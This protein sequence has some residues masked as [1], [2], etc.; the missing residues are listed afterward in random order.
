MK[1]QL[2]IACLTLITLSAT[3]QE[4]KESK[5]KNHEITADLD[6][7]AGQSSF[8]LSLDAHYDWFLLKSKKIFVGVGPRFTGFSG[9]NVSFTSAPNE[10][11][12]EEANI[13]T[14]LAP[15][16]FIYS[17]NV[18][19]NLGYRFNERLSAGFNIDLVGLSFG[20]NGTPN[21][22]SNG[23]ITSVKVNPT[24]MNILLVGN[25]DRGTLNSQFYLK[26][27]FN[28]KLGVKIAFQYLFNEL[29]TE[30]EVQTFPVNNDR[31]RAKTVQGALGIN[32]M[33]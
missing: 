8:A 6:L 15:S 1:K 3:A 10:L 2:T 5:P 33:F 19:L 12:L 17:A 13:D 25:N 23:N 28:S 18:F 7:A 9:T 30:T 20:P 31:F 14:V 22:I 26:Y 21:F 11:A 24:P 32:Y 4:T 29:T 16:P 27:K